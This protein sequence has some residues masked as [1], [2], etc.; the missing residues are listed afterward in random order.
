[1]T[2]VQYAGNGYDDIQLRNLVHDLEFASIELAGM[3]SRMKKAFKKN[4]FVYGTSGKGGGHAR[5]ANIM[6]GAIRAGRRLVHRSTD[7][8]SPDRT[9]QAFG[10][11]EP[12]PVFSIFQAGPRQH[13]QRTHNHQMMDMYYGDEE[14]GGNL[15]DRADPDIL[16]FV[17]YAIK[18]KFLNGWQEHNTWLKSPDSS[19]NHPYSVLK[20]MGIAQ[21]YYTSPQTDL[22]YGKDDWNQQYMTA[23][24]EISR[25]IRWGIQEYGGTLVFDGAE[26]YYDQVFSQRDRLADT[27]LEARILFQ[28]FEPNKSWARFGQGKIEFHWHGKEVVPS[29]LL[30]LTSWV[31]N[32]F[33]ARQWFKLV[34]EG[35]F[36]PSLSGL[37]N[38][39]DQQYLSVLQEKEIWD[40]RTGV[41][42]LDIWNNF[43]TFPQGI[44]LWA[45]RTW[46]KSLG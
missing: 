23:T 27:D 26:V 20:N 11:K 29:K 16:A 34:H 33:A 2:I 19:G 4:T 3:V 44:P 6:T 9:V 45:V 42:F 5:L 39:P 28:Y 15:K 30:F 21:A 12:G 17:M 13:V 18:L 35:N 14:S 41:E 24:K 7:I 8:D 31:F 10:S 36:A 25:V 22:M 43:S 38:N 32:D 37:K 1:M 46:L 40:I